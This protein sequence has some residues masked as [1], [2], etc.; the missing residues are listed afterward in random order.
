MEQSD[1]TPPLEVVRKRK[2][3]KR[4]RGRKGGK[5]GGRARVAKGFAR[6]SREEIQ[7]ISAKAVA[8]RRAKRKD[9]G[10]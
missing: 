2:L 7:A 9:T 6:L 4:E 1:S 10:Q 8:A 3:S 5:V